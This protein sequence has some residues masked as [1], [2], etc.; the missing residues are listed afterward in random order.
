MGV[1]VR[2]RASVASCGCS[3]LLL[4]ISQNIAAL[5]ICSDD[6]NLCDADIKTSDFR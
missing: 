3:F 2:L 4:Q 6:P 5:A 1:S